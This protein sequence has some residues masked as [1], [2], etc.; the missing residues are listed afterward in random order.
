[1]ILRRGSKEC[2]RFELPQVKCKREINAPDSAA[3]IDLMEEKL[4]RDRHFCRRRLIRRAFGIAVSPDAPR[5][6]GSKSPPHLHASLTEG[7]REWYISPN[8]PTCR[9]WRRRH[10]CS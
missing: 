7:P 10:G 9:A 3:T 5:Q 6:H 4:L 1:M 8:R 2:S